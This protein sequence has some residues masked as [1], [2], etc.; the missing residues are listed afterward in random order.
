M[1]GMSN[2]LLTPESV[3]QVAL[4]VDDI[5]RTAANYA[6]VFGVPV[7]NIIETG[8]AA[9]TTIRFRGETTP[10][11]AK[12]TFF[13]LGALQLELIEP[14]DGP[15]TWREVLEKNGAGLHH[16]AF[17]VGNSRETSEKLAGLGATVVQTGEF[18][19]GNY[20]YVDATRP[21]GAVLELLEIYPTGRAPS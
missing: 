16:I 1:P 11:R 2:P 17:R 18:G 19:T 7:P 10:G 14:I 12:L 9:K 13:N 4:V 15:S 5:A 8:P 20:A 6:T 3:C 21:L